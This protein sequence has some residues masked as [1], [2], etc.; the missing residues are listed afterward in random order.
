MTGGTPPAAGGRRSARVSS[1]S[2]QRAY[3]SLARQY[4]DA[5]GSVEQ[6]H[7]DDLA[8]IRRHLGQA[9]GRVLD[10][11]C[12]PGHL[13]GFLHSLDVDVSGIDLVPEFLAHARRSHPGVGFEVGSALDVERP[14]G[15]L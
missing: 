9:R 5:L 12:G 1:E 4:I 15:S 10:I 6:V 3:S 13:S 11:G 2:V 8:F 14:D 7:P